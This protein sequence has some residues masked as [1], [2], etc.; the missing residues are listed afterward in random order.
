MFYQFIK[1]PNCKAKIKAV[2]KE[3]RWTKW[4]EIYCSECDYRK[5]IHGKDLDYIQPNSPFFEAI[6]G[7]DP[8]ELARRERRKEEN[9]KE[10]LKTEREVGLKLNKTLKPWD[11]DYIKKYVRERELE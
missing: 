11:R 3:N 6:Y 2:L 8:I 1:C 10:N 9:K 4:I 7:N 5:N